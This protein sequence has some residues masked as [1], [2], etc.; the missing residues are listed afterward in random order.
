ME[1]ARLKELV[2]NVDKH[3]LTDEEKKKYSGSFI[4]LPCGETHYEIKGSGEPIVLVHGFAT[5]YF[6]YDKIFVFF[7]EKGYKVLRYDL[8]GRG[9][10]ERVKGRYTPELF[11]RQLKE[12]SDE[13]IKEDKFIL[14]GTS[15]GGAV[16]AAFTAMNPERVKKIFWLAPAGMNFNP[17]LYMKIANIPPLG[18][19]MFKIAGGKILLVNSCKELIYHREERDYYLEKFA[20]CARYKGFFRATLSSMR[21][22]LMKNDKTVGYYKRVS[23]AK[24]PACALWGTADKT[25]PY[26]QSEQLKQIFPDIH[27]YTYEGSGHI[28][29]FDEGEKTCSILYNEIC[30]IN[31]TV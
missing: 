13:L 24:I 19:L 17:P 8:L 28:F 2:K 20:E 15:M 9:L 30:E 21:H 14:M 22:T 7:V 27:F 10:S 3:E 11:A 18:E 12:L 6:I 5:P 26:Y 1:D 29:L 31:Q 4:K 16:T 23:A 25:M